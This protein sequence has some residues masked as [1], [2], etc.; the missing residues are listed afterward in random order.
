MDDTVQC[1]ICDTECSPLPRVG[2]AAGF[3]C[4][5]HGRF[6]VSDTVFSRNLRGDWEAALERAKAHAAIG[7]LPT[8]RTYDFNKSP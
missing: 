6:K 3:D 1:P 2:D 5:R 7:E 8:I 4:P